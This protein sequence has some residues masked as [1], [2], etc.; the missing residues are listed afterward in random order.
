MVL[1]TSSQV[2]IVISCVVGNCVPSWHRGHKANANTIVFLFTSALFL[3]GYVVQQ[4]TVRDLRAAIKPRPAPEPELRLY[5]PKQFQDAK[6]SPKENG[7]EVEV[8]TEDIRNDVADEPLAKIELR[9]EGEDIE[10]VVEEEGK[11]SEDEEIDSARY[12]VP[13]AEQK[14]V[15]EGKPETKETPLSRA[16]RRKK[17]KE[18]IMEG[19][20]EHG[21]KGYRRRMW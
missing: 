13:S 21:F 5:L 10:R 4:Q 15:F 8:T 7:V 14:L 6:P 9:N 18:E 3:S 16:A 19:S 2:S 12:D 17:I 20:E 11:E 1:L